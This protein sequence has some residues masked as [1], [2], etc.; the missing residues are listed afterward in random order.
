M[1]QAGCHRR[2]RE[3]AI[4]ALPLLF[5]LIACDGFPRDTEDSSARIAA[6]GMRVGWVSGDEARPELRALVGRLDQGAG[7]QAGVRTGSAEALL[8]GL[9]AGELDLVV[10]RF[11]AK[12]PWAKR[13]TFSQPLQT[14]PIAGEELQSVAATRNGEHAWAMTV[15]KAVAATGGR[16]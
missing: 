11:D 9:E 1:D 7:R 10:G 4:W 8:M 13:V 3:R 2:K 14:A 15:D 16:S 6:D 5:A 12:S